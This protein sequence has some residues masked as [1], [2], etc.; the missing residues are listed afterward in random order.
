MRCD[1]F[2][3]WETWAPCSSRPAWRATWVAG[4]G[5]CF[6]SAAAVLVTPIFLGLSHLFTMNAFDPLLW[7]LLA[8]LM[9]KL[10]GIRESKAVAR[11]GRPYWRHSAE[12]IRQSCSSC[13][14]LLAGRDPYSVAK[15]LVAPLV[16]A[17]RCACDAD[18]VAQFPVAAKLALPLRAVDRD[19]R[20]G[21][22]DVMLPPLP[23]SGSRRR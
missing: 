17:W 14:G 16:L 3:C 9:V 20:S 2:P 13:R 5:R 22:R 15:S 18:C 11:R 12:Q 23:S 10:V 6:L 21:P 1:C 19:V 8:W 4:A 7:A